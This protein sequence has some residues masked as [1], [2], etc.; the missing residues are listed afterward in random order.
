MA[1]FLGRN[2]LSISITADAGLEFLS[3]S[4][5]LSSLAANNP[6]CPSLLSFTSHSSPL[7]SFSDEE[8]ARE[9][10]LGICLFQ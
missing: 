2:R 1:A 7:L 6:S 8:K 10:W 3:L 4:I 9:I 5:Y